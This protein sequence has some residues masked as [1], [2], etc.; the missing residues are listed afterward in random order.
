MKKIG[1]L[2][3]FC[4]AVCLTL[5]AGCSPAQ[6]VP[7]SA[8]SSEVPSSEP[9]SSAPAEPVS[10]APATEA[11]LVFDHQ[12]PLDYAECFTVNYY[13]G[14]YKKIELADGMKLLVVPEGAAVPECEEGTAVLQQPVG[15]LL[16]TSTPT[17]SLIN[18]LGA[19]DAVSMTT[20]AADSWYI[21]EVKDAVEKGTIAYIGDHRAP[22][23]EQI[24]AAGVKFAVCSGMLKEDVKQQL[25]SLGVTVM[26]DGAGGERHPLGRS[27]WLKLYGA[28]FN[29]EK[30][31]E[32]LMEKQTAV[33]DG[34]A[35]LENTGKTVSI[36]Y[37]TTKGSI[38]TRCSEDYAAKMVELAGGKYLPENFGDGDSGAVPVEPEAFYEMAK[39][40]D[41]LIYIWSMGG[42]PDSFAEVLAQN[43]ILADLKAVKEGN[44]WCTAPEYFQVTDALG[45]MTADIRRMLEA[46][47]EDETL[48]WLYR[49]R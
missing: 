32:A 1:R 2:Q 37:I 7:S 46:G 44:V 47:P 42:K 14:G 36:F 38:Y 8:A 49:M 13:Q 15:N 40:A 18:A 30:E 19:L 25:E 48:T 28:L 39:D 5:F 33:V 35:G 24:T 31:A 34:L 27:E 3:A 29:K 11:D 9:S 16:L 21:D 4:L 6:Q 17:A 41:C 26:L 20:V 12:M 43:E 23:Y 45:E 10:K 22:D